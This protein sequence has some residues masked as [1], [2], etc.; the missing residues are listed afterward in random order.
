MGIQ[1]ATQTAEADAGDGS[2]SATAW[3]EDHEVADHVDFPDQAS[4]PSAPSAGFLRLFNRQRAGRGLLHM[5]GPAGLDT[6]LQPALFGNSVYMWLPGTGTTLGIN[7]GTNFTARNSGTAAAQAHPTK[8]STS[9]ITSMNRATFGTGTTATGA[10]GVQSGQSVAWRGNAAGLGGFFFF[11]RFG[12]ETLASDQ[13]VFVGLSA[14]NAAMAADPSTWNNTIG[15][16]KD[17]GDT[18]WQILA[19]GTAA[20]KTDT[21]QAVTQGQILDL[22]LFAPPNGSDI[23]VRLIDTT[24]GTVI[25]DDV[26]QSSNLPASTTFMFMQAHTQSQTGATAKL[27]A[28]NRM[29]CETDL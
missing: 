12:V 20:T 21:G 9:A 3:N 28:L 17:T 15:L 4:V 26:A 1:H 2:I 27:L 24:A 8:T 11:A 16:C 29:Y 25:V 19:R 13:R 18:N 14:N 10:S 5:I 22:L 6:A 7:F 23:T